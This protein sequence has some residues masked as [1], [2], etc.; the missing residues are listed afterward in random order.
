MHTELLEILRCPLTGQRLAL[1]APV[2]HDDFIHEGWL[3]T[4]D[5]HHRYPIRNS[6]PRFVPE[7]NYADTFGLQWNQFRQ[8]QLDSHSGHPI[9][10]NRFWKAT[11]W[12]AEDIVGQWML[13]AGCGAGRFAEVALQAGATVVAVDYSSAVDACYASLNKHRKLHVVQADICALPFSRGYFQFV[14]SLGVLQHTPDVEEA[15]RA[16]PP[17]LASGGQICADFYWGRL[18]TMLHTKY[19]LRPITKR[20]NQRKLL[21]FLETVTPKLLSVSQFLGRI[22]RLGR[23]LKRIVPIADYTGVYPLDANQLQEWALLDTFDM[24]ASRY[25]NPQTVD[26]VRRFFENA[27]LAQVDV[28]HAGHLVGRGHKN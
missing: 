10:A 19:L 14:Y 26:T 18:I 24:L 13:D 6:I 23:V 5:G 4:E 27:G 7:S 25:D 1:E 2:F 11:A 9:S 22:P 21:K 3:V 28:V 8:T 15:F 17:M 16:L 20:I 12:S